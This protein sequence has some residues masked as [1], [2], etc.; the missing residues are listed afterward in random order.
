MQL[1]TN[2]G[3]REIEIE[4]VKSFTEGLFFYQIICIS[5]C[6]RQIIESQNGWGAEIGRAFW[7]HQLQPL[8]KQGQPEQDAQ[9]HI[10]TVV[11]DL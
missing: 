3:V 9:N 4:Y 2:K 1:C 8:P 10:Q 11:E 6:I 5:L 7:I